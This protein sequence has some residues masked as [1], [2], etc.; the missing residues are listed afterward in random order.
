MTNS[1]MRRCFLELSDELDVTGLKESRCIQCYTC[2]PS[3]ERFS[4][5]RTEIQNSMDEYQDYE[6]FTES[7]ALQFRSYEVEV[8]DIG[9]RS[10]AAAAA[11]E[12]LETP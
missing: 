3:K 5:V 11:G 4:Q 10:E 8:S 12:I 2:V 1:L 7:Q 9:R 6:E